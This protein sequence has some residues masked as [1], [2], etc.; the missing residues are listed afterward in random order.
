MAKKPL[1]ERVR[2]VGGNLLIVTDCDGTEVEYEIDCGCEPVTENP[3]TTPPPLADDRC[4]TANWYAHCIGFILTT[5]QEKLNGQVN[6]VIGRHLAIADAA[7][8]LGLPYSPWAFYMNGYIGAENPQAAANRANLLDPTW[9]NQ[10]N[11]DILVCIIHDILE[12]QGGIFTYDKF[13]TGMEA[14]GWFASGV[15]IAQIP[16]GIFLEKVYKMSADVG[17]VYQT[18]AGIVDTDCEDCDTGMEPTECPGDCETTIC[19]RLIPMPMGGNDFVVTGY[20]NIVDFAA[21]NDACWFGTDFNPLRIDMGENYCVKRVQVI[22]YT[23]CG[24]GGGVR[25]AHYRIEID[26]VNV[27]DFKCSTLNRAQY[28]PCGDVGGFD[29]AG[30]IQFEFATPFFGRRINIVPLRKELTIVQVN[31]ITCVS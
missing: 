16:I 18:V 12:Q 4:G 22:S 5:I 24:A 27:S 10:D 25:S 31:V 7:N 17:G 14:Q 1:T 30:V 13:L 15:V 11:N 20:S 26:D 23:P 2:V 9:D 28:L 8:Y 3:G 19:H 29:G 6:N 21:P